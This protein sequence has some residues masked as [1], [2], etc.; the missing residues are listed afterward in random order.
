MTS[1]NE[2]FRIR[3]NAKIVTYPDFEDMKFRK[4][5]LFYPSASEII[6]EREVHEKFDEEDENGPIVQRI[7]R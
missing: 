6:D 2:V 3:S 5:L 7:E 4:V 1:Q